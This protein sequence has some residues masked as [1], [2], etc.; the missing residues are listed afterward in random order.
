MQLSKVALAAVASLPWVAKVTEKLTKVKG[1]VN[2]KLKKL[3]PLSPLSPL[4]PFSP[5][6]PLSP[7]N[8]SWAV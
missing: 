4:S 7:L 2:E 8:S 5:L 1:K 6:S 3:A